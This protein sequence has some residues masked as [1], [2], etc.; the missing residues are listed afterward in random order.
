VNCTILLYV[1]I[2]KFVV[3]LRLRGAVACSKK[4]LYFVL[5]R[6]ESRDCTMTRPARSNM[7]NSEVIDCRYTAAKMF[8]T[9]VRLNMARG[10]NVQ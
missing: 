8:S 7:V 10:R 9:L 5:I 1:L 4:L 6:F 2:L 3:I